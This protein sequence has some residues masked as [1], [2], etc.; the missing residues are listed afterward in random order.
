[1]VVPE[2]RR[3]SGPSGSSA[4]IPVRRR[5]RERPSAQTPRPDGLTVRSAFWGRGR[6]MKTSFYL[7]AAAVAAV[8]GG[9]VEAQDAAEKAKCE[10]LV[11]TANL[12]ITSA[13]VL[14][15]NGKTPAYCY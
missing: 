3:K 10:G 1:M 15:A 6:K 14:A 5:S 7:A 12:T 11:D 2:T 8:W 4:H 9:V 13:R